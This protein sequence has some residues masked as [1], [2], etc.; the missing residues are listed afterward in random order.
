MEKLSFNRVKYSVKLVKKLGEI[1]EVMEN[2]KTI[3]F[4]KD[5]S[6]SQISLEQVFIDFARKQVM[7]S[8]D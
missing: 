4:I 6:F 2:C 5:Y 7:I 8:D 1:F 3:N